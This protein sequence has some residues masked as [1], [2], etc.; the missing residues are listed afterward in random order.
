MRSERKSEIGWRTRET[1]ERVKWREIVDEDRMTFSFILISES[2][3]CYN[4]FFLRLHSLAL[5]TRSDSDMDTHTHTQSRRKGDGNELCLSSF[6]V[7]Q[8][9]AHL[10]GLFYFSMKLAIIAKFSGYC[11]Q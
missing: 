9:H 5:A 11:V 10:R 3:T 4:E 7:R 1:E 6:G 2:S 8:I